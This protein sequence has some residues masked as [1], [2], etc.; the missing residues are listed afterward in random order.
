ML[1]FVQI[2]GPSDVSKFQE[3]GFTV[4]EADE[5][6]AILAA[7]PGEKFNLSAEEIIRRSRRGAR[8][9]GG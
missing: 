3:V 4:A 1:D 5:V 2:E 6:H 8:D 7:E 9:T